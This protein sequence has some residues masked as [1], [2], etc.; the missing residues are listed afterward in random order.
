V[1]LAAAFGGHSEAH[2]T[3]NLYKRSLL[4][5]TIVKYRIAT[6]D[7]QHSLPY[8]IAVGPVLPEIGTTIS[9]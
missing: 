2:A 5:L 8:S 7:L 3:A 1:L 4:P 6:V 9:K